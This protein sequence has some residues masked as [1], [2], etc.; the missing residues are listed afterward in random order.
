MTSVQKA[1]GVAL[2]GNEVIFSGYFHL[3]DI[4]LFRK[5]VQKEPIVPF[6]D[7]KY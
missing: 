7:K 3:C 2:T 5:T 4:L 6:T 1:L